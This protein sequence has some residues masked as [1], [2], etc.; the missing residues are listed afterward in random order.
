MYSWLWIFF[1]YTRNIVAWILILVPDSGVALSV[2]RWSY[3]IAVSCKSLNRIHKMLCAYISTTATANIQHFTTATHTLPWIKLEKKL[4]HLQA[5]FRVCA[6][7]VYDL[8][9]EMST[10]VGTV[11]YNHTIENTTFIFSSHIFTD[12]IS[13][14][15][16]IVVNKYKFTH[17]QTDGHTWAQTT[18][19]NLMLLL[20]TYYYYYYHLNVAF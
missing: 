14:C 1:H 17:R 6:C 7:V 3:A 5:I 20:L 2:G 9:R 19:Y 16:G 4:S 10:R 12:F 8:C 15:V 18:D 11:Q 13:L